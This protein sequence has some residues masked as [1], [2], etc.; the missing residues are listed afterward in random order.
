MLDAP[1]ERGRSTTRQISRRARS[2]CGAFAAL[3]AVLSLAWVAPWLSASV[4]PQLSIDRTVEYAAVAALSLSVRA[5]LAEVTVWC[6]VRLRP[7]TARQLRMSPDQTAQAVRQIAPCL[8]LLHQQLD[9]ALKESER[10][11]LAVIHQIGEAHQVSGQQFERIHASE[12]Q[13]IA[14]TAVMNEKVAMDR[15][16]GAILGLFV[17][18]QEADAEANL[19]RVQRLQSIKEL[20]SLVDVIADIAR[21]T[22]ILAINAAI[23]AARAGTSGL[24][25]AVVA[26]EIRQLSA[27][28]AAAAGAI[29]EKI[30]TATS[31]INTDYAEATPTGHNQTSTSSLRQVVS[32]V[33]SM[34]VRFSAA[35]LQLQ[36]VLDG[37]KSGHAGIVERLSAALGEIQTQDV[38]RQRVEQVQKVMQELGLHAQAVALQLG[39]VPFD[40]D[41]LCRLAHQLQAQSADYVMHS[42]RLTHQQV[43]GEVTEGH[44]ERPNIELF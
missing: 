5:G 33:A 37:I 19:G 34:Q 17:I 10:G 9:G 38:V 14:L 13:G 43:T 26:G 40:P 35:A 31:G 1:P 42:Q 21:Q 3:L 8:D 27:Q 25:F 2:A 6:L 41:L 20:A 16:L 39:D 32:D 44:S 22:N 29:A 24:G 36:Q 18:K 11:A 28:T 23:E 15:H 7:D 4:W 12:R 30:L